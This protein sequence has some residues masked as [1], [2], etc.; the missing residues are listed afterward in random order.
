MTTDAIRPSR[1]G[2]PSPDRLSGWWGDW[3]ETDDWIA[4]I[5][6]VLRRRGPQQSSGLLQALQ[7]EAQKSGGSLP[8][9]SQPPTST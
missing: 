2:S 5:Q 3:F 1:T 4:S 7:V 6:D 9:T 8:V